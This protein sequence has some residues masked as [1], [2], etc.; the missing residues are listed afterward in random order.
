[1][2]DTYTLGVEEEYQLIQPETRE[3][4]GRAGKVLKSARQM[5]AGDRVQPE[6]HRCQIEIATNVC[7]SLAELRNELQRSRQVV[8]ES[9]RQQGVAVVAAGTH[10]FSAW[11]D[12]ALTAKDRYQELAQNL[13]QVIRELII[14]GCHVH[15][16]LN[17][18]Q[19]QQEPEIAL[20]IVNRCRL[21]LSPLL[22]LTA[23]SPFWHAAD[24]G[25]DSYRTE[26]WCR[27]PTAGPPP[28]FESL[29]A[30]ESFIQSLIQSQVIPDITMLYWDI[31]LSEAFPTIEFRIADVCMTVE[32]AVMLAGLIKA[33]VRTTY[34]EAQSGDAYPAVK[35]ELL[36][37]AH[38][39]AARYGVSA[40]LIDL[41]QAIAVPARDHVAR[42]LDYLRPAL[43]AEGDWDVVVP[44]VQQVLEQGNGAARQRRWRQETGSL[45]EVVDHLIAQT[46]AG[47]PA[48]ACA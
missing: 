14:F 11:Q 41:Q 25:Y 15:V 35:S 40:Q 43:E 48:L 4:C 16:G 8:I 7:N 2:S 10:P 37:A 9:A 21:W 45:H 28:H 24:T 13:K 6:M 26:L 32:E 31:R 23:N 44:L 34:A 42:L 38:W 20:D 46:A 19:F 36:K 17:G 12:Q 5:A 27:L 29:A 18:D 33:L 39:T 22:A 1:M 47:V 3:L 30:Y